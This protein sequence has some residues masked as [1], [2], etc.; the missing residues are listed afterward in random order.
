LAFGT[1]ILAVAGGLVGVVNGVM[2]LMQGAPP[3]AP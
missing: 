2:K 3:N 1:Q